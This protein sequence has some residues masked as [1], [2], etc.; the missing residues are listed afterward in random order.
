MFHL[1][2]IVDLHR[3]IAQ[4]NIQRLLEALECGYQIFYRV[5][6]PHPLCSTELG[7]FAI[8]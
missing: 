1:D 3:N 8:R 7:A 5:S 6:A 4:V 2:S